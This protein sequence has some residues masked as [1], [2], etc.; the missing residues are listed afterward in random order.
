MYVYKYIEGIGCDD[1]TT[2]SEFVHLGPDVYIIKWIFYVLWAVRE[3]AY[4]K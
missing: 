3:N 1:W 2:W 4:R